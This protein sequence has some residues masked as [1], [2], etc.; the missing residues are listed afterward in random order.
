MFNELRN[1]IHVKLLRF[2]KKETVVAPTGKFVNPYAKSAVAKGKISPYDTDYGT[3]KTKSFGEFIF[4]KK[5]EPLVKDVV[6]VK[7]PSILHDMKTVYSRDVLFLASK[8]VRIPKKE[9]RMTAEEIAKACESVS[10]QR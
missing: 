10:W 7:E 3:K 9:K 4:P 1:K 5:P 8:M 2:K 6:V